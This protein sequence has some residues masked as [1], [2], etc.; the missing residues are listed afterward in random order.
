MTKNLILC[1]K[2]TA[3]YICRGGGELFIKNTFT[4]VAHTVEFVNL[5][6]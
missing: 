5:Q 2:I 4:W 3:L 1:E 6:V